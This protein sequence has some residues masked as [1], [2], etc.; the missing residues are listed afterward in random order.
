MAITTEQLADSLKQFRLD[1]ID[2]L[3]NLD[4]EIHALRQA[5]VEEN[6][7]TTERFK[8]ILSDSQKAL[9]QFRNYH[10]Q[11]ISPVHESQ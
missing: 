6:P 10:A 8:Q 3:S 5:I 2:A 9:H 1:V 4:V 7:V 11:R